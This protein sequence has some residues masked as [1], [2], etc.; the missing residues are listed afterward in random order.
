M[1]KLQAAVLVPVCMA[2]AACGGGSS[3]SGPAPATSATIMGSASGIP[4]GHTVLLG[5]N[6]TETISVG[7]DGNF[8]FAKRVAEGGKYNVTVLGVPSGTNCVV[9]NGAGT[10]THGMDSVTNVGVTCAND[11][12]IAFLN[13]YVGVTVSGLL[14]GNSVTLT[15]NGTDTLTV[16]DNSLQL[17]PGPY[18]AQAVYSGRAGG[19]E[20]AVK[21]NPAG[22]T[23]TLS[24]ASGAVTGYAQNNF[25]NVLVSCK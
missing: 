24:N 2:L 25:V 21:T 10:V 13:F 7:A 17:F 12:A 16:S 4:S 18:A 19:Y 8:A 1:I 3:D 15:N 14:A 23:C 11:G 6:G 5:N 9:S 22:Q 20:V